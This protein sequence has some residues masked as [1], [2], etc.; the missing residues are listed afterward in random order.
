MH[1]CQYCQHKSANPHQLAAHMRK[2]QVWKTWRAK[3]LTKE[4]LEKL[5]V[6]EERSMPEIA[7]ILKLPSVSIVYNDLKRFE[8]EVRSVKTSATMPRKQQRSI[9][10]CIQRY[11]AM[12]PMSS[13]TEPRRSMQEK[14]MRE[15]GVTNVFQ[16]PDVK[17]KIRDSLASRPESIVSRFSNLHKEV[18]EFVK[19][20]ALQPELEFCIPFDGGY[21]SYDIR[22]DNRLIE[23]HGD[24]WHANPKNYNA[25][26]VVEWSMGTMT[27]EQIWARDEFKRELAVKSGY[28]LLVVWESDWKKC[29]SDTERSI[30]Q[31]IGMNNA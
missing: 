20:I 12:N 27:A 31:F 8:I 2:C 4:V 13:N 19:S 24:Y 28:N 25:N 21:R 9:N 1:L 30:M 16:L 22:V 29:K 14:L 26:D 3:H 11:G 23:V 18:F 10:T 6:E 15:Y 7:E 17:L 5:Y